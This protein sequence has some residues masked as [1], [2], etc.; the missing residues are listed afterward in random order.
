MLPSP[1]RRRTSTTPRARRCRSQPTHTRSLHHEAAATPR[2]AASSTQLAH[3]TPRRRHGNATELSWPPALARARA[4]GWRKQYQTR[5]AAS[6]AGASDLARARNRRRAAF[7][8]RDKNDF[9][10]WNVHRK[11][12]DHE[13]ASRAGRAHAPRPLPCSVSILTCSGTKAAHAAR[14]RVPVHAW[15]RFRVSCV[16]SRNFTIVAPAS[17]RHRTNAHA[18]A[19]HAL[20]DARAVTK[21]RG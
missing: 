20:R 1:S 3:R 7:H 8:E 2:R 14:A 21:T 6:L 11:L 13:P 17:R 18:P 5:A 9:L 4:C 12:P 10:K 16:P 15:D 19:L